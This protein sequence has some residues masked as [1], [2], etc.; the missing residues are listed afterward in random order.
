MKINWRVL[1]KAMQASCTLFGLVALCAWFAAGWPWYVQAGAAAAVLAVVICCYMIGLAFVGRGKRG[2]VRREL[3]R[4][5]KK[6]AR[7]RTGQGDQSWLATMSMPEVGP[8]YR[9]RFVRVNPDTGNEEY[10]YELMS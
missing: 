2:H 4:I 3:A 10:K 9:K 1:G 6:L 7:A 5:D 8:L